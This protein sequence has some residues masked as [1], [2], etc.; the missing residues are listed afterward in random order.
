MGS[1]PH[2]P[3][4]CAR[5]TL[6]SLGSTEA[7]RGKVVASRD[8]LSPRVP[9]N[10]TEQDVRIRGNVPLATEGTVQLALLASCRPRGQAL[11]TGTEVVDPEEKRASY[12]LYLGGPVRSV[13]AQRKH[14]AH[15]SC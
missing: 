10:I 5:T 4:Q 3:L 2:V 7:L 14:K 12:S 8:Q 1:W 11:A 9:S 13:M 6:G 15:R